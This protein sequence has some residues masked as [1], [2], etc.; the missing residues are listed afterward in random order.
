[1]KTTSRHRSRGV[2]L[3]RTKSL[4][5]TVVLA[6]ATGVALVALFANASL[7]LGTSADAATGENQ[8]VSQQLSITDLGTLGGRDS[9]AYQISDHGQVVA[10]SSKASGREHALVWSK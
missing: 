3:V 1:M 6:L 4:G 7:S 5:M 9:D 8:L 10:Y 2:P